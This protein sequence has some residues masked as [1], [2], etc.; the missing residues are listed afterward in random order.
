MQ[1]SAPRDESPVERPVTASASNARPLDDDERNRI[2]ADPPLSRERCEQLFVAELPTIQ[3][4]VAAIA[5]RH[6]LSTAE[7]EDFAAEVHLRIISDDYAV[8]RKFRSRCKLRT[9]LCVVIA[10][11]FL[12]YRN[13][14]WGKWRPSARSRRLGDD[15]VRFEQLTVRDG[16]TFDEACAV[17]ETNDHRAV[18]RKALERVYA[19]FRRRGRPRFV[20]EAAIA[21]EAVAHDTADQRL[22]TTDAQRV[23]DRATAVVREALSAA[24]PE[25]RLI[26]KLRF[27]DGLSVADVSRQ[28]ALDQ[29]RLYR[30]LERLLGQ[31]R[32]SLSTDG[33]G[34]VDVLPALIRSETNPGIVFLPDNVV[35]MPVRRRRAATFSLR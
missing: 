34:A 31:L 33:L 7:A 17:L 19:R 5:R 6:R 21:D 14:Q 18:D 26:L 2:V 24:T 28:L 16:L 25:D 27:K 8:L 22:V 32:A 3:R 4:L 20:G 30:R 13:T 10:R 35:P 9:F 12:D 15:A 29:K 11:L 1:Q 23:V